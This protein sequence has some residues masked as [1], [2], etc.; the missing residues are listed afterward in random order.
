MTAQQ[1][2]AIDRFWRHVDKTSTCWNYTGNR[3]KDGYGILRQ[4][5]G[6]S[7]CKAHRFSFRLA[8]GDFDERLWVLHSCDNP[9]CVNPDHLFLGTN[10][11]N[12]NDMVVKGRVMKGDRH[13]RKLHPEKYPRG[14]RWPTSKLTA[15]KA[16][17][18]K[19]LLS[20]GATLRSLGRVF[21]VSK[22]T[23][24]GIRDGRL[25]SHIVLSKSTSEVP[26]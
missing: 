20:S 3:D 22:Q 21:G 25:W 24:A 13:H 5:F 8:N 4:G 6:I 15:D 2:T 16:L 1:R 11:D 9:S 17:K 18:I 10:I 12:V 23:I 26:E 19:Q 7:K 14:E